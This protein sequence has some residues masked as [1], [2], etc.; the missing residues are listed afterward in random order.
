[1][2]AA[3]TQQPIEQFLSALGSDQPTP[4][5]GAAAAL[6]AALAAQLGHKAGALTVGKP[7]FAEVEQQVGDLMQ[8]LARATEML[9]QLVSEDAVAY[10][11][12]AAA[13]K[14]PKDRDDRAEQIEVAASYAAG[15]PLQ[16]A[17]LTRRVIRTLERIRPIANPNLVSDVDVGQALARAAL[18]SAA[19]NVRVNLPFVNQAH[20]EVVA[21]E[22]EQICQLDRD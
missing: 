7:R 17:A 12:L 21:R 3:L 13:F 19:I 18:E 22:L 16:T 14:L 4:G 5:G 1:M 2:N 11:A 6:S 20:R 10:E 15:V 8:R 9:K